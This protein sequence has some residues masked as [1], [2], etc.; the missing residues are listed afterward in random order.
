M[1]RRT[2]LWLL[3][4]IF[5]IIEC[6]QAQTDLFT[7]YDARSKA[8]SGAASIL[9]NSAYVFLWN[10][11]N[12]SEIYRPIFSINVNQLFTYDQA[13]IA[14]LLPGVGNVGLAI[15][16]LPNLIKTD[17]VA[18]AWSKK[19]S[20]SL[21]IGLTNLI[22][23]RNEKIA[24]EWQFGIAYSVKSGRKDEQTETHLHRRLDLAAVLKNASITPKCYGQPLE[25]AVGMH[26]LVF[27]GI[28][29]FYAE[30]QFNKKQ[31]HFISA[32]E[33]NA[34]QYITFRS[35][36][37]DLDQH[38][39]LFG[40]GLHLGT[41]NLDFVYQRYLK[42][43][44]FSSTIQFG[45]PP[46]DRAESY[47]QK[48]L[49]QL[50][51]NRLKSA[52]RQFRQAVA[53]A[54]END[55]YR[56]IY[57]S[58]KNRHNDL[59][60]QEKQSFDEAQQYEKKGEVVAALLRYTDILAGSPT[61]S[62]VLAKIQLLKP[63]ARFQ[64]S[65]IK[66]TAIDFYERGEL[67]T[68]RKIFDRIKIID[69]QDS[70]IQRYL[71]LVEEQQKKQ[72][73]EHFYRGLGYYSQKNFLAA[74]RE[75]ELANEL[76]PDY[77]EIETYLK[78]VQDQKQLNKKQVDSLLFEAAGQAAKGNVNNAID[79]YSSILELDAQNKEARLALSELKPRVEAHIN[80]LH[81]QAQAAVQNQNY[82]RAEAIYRDI[83]LLRPNDDKTMQLL[84]KSRQ[85]RTELA[86]SFYQKGER[87]MQ[88]QLDDEALQYYRRAVELDRNEDQYATASQRVEKRL[89]LKKK[90]QAANKAFQDN[91]FVLAESLT[92]EL[93]NRDPN[94]PEY[95]DFLAQV[96]TAKA[97][98]GT[99]LLQNG[100]HLYS[101]EKYDEAIRTFDQL[102]EIDQENQTAQ[103]Y[104]KRIQEK[105]RALEKLK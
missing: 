100:I 87:A 40:C 12:L 90:W 23:N 11:A 36:I 54:P 82:Y 27:P 19:V 7:F 21:N 77:G 92:L 104:K 47:Y 30:G 2:Q 89:E 20:S 49:E 13:A 55:S 64:L 99:F 15:G 51:E 39:W 1:K 22:L 10:P 68:A 53:F 62:E 98:Y 4:S 66:A 65:K 31:N 105:I 88:R 45:E 91:N 50:K 78:A 57:S 16:R 56:Q 73:E 38:H 72:A 97:R 67:I 63:R 26:Y 41:F 6:A 28:F 3:L 52:L 33:L 80:E 46:L 74:E 102:L 17:Y 70:V 59:R 101:Q 37:A 24:M 79:N 29:D 85:S 58:T 95:L 32:V 35:G 5:G 60:K 93:L 8:L 9:T 96:R 83:L 81:A 103:E 86:K 42:Q 75:F 76:S 34:S 61:N 14:S 25:L 18:V 48:G 71:R 84:R 94:V 43:I 44:E 69:P